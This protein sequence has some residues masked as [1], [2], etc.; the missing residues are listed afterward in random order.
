MAAHFTP[1]TMRFLRGLAKNNDRTWFEE[2]RPVYER[3]VKA[4]LLDLVSEIN[5][6]LDAFAPEFIRPPH[7]V[8]MRIF[9]DIRF[10]PDKRPYKSNLSAWWARRGL[11]KS[12][13]AGFYLQ[14]GP[15]GSFLAAGVYAPER[16]ALHAL[17]TWLAEHHKE[18]RTQ[19][20]PLLR[21]TKKLPAMSPMDPAALTRN[22][23]G[24]PADHPASDL[25]R[26]R[27]WGVTLSL[28]DD[29]A[30]S[31]EL[32]NEVLQ[33]FRRATPLVTLLNEALVPRGSGGASHP[34]RLHPLRTSA[35][36]IGHR[37]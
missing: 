13:G 17:R 31:A 21:G 4:P 25:L 19:I 16:D 20:A 30:L 34:R 22:P 37:V 11:E 27:N 8:A 32:A 2:R 29:A 5:A 35:K 18:Y 24:F 28:S 23:K 9:R 6:G 12:S 7:K 26:P 33:G 15:A 36:F 14:V 3:V 1:E 10:S